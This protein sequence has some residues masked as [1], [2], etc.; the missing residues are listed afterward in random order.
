MHQQNKKNQDLVETIKLLSFEISKGKYLHLIA[1][2]KLLLHARFQNDSNFIVHESLERI[3]L[4][5]I[6]TFNTIYNA[7][8]YFTCFIFPFFYVLKHSLG[9]EFFEGLVYVLIVNTCF[10]V[11]VVFNLLLSEEKKSSIFRSLLRK[12]PF[13]IVLIFYKLRKDSLIIS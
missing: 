11:F 8:F 7:L 12:F 2:Y 13:L 9:V 6:N 3:E 1:L 5:A 10:I 4:A